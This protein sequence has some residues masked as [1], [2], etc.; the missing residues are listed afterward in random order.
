M[1]EIVKS[2]VLKVFQNKN[3][4]VSADYIFRKRGC[5]GLVRN[6]SFLLYLS[7]ANIGLL[8]VSS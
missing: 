3:P 2:W 4:H 5:M 8:I 7:V 6:M 1:R